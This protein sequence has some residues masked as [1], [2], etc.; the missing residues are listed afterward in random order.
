MKRSLIPWRTKKCFEESDFNNEDILNFAITLREV[1]R[2]L[3]SN[4]CWDLCS[5]KNKIMLKELKHFSASH[6]SIPLY[7][8]KDARPL[9]LALFSICPGLDKEKI[10]RIGICRCNH[11]LN[12]SHYYYGNNLNLSIERWKRRGHRITEEIYHEVRRLRELD[13]KTYTYKQLAYKFNLKIHLVESICHS[14][15]N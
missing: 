9:I 4:H 12:P 13:P 7:K 3:D 11:C 14:N 15:A 10:I 8:G 2:L 1:D 6:K 5:I